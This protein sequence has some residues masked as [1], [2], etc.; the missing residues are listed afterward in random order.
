M[1]SDE[2][3]ISPFE[4]QALKVSETELAAEGAPKLKAIHPLLR[5]AC[6]TGG[7]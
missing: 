6:L 3:T 2:N 7:T 5:F 4:L 1:P